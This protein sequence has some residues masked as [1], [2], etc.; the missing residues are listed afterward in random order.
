MTFGFINYLHIREKYYRISLVKIF[1]NTIV[2]HKLQTGKVLK[3]S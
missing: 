3:H 2:D 1:T